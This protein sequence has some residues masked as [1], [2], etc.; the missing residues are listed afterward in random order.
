MTRSSFSFFGIL[1]LM[2]ALSGTARAEE[3]MVPMDAADLSTATGG[4]AT[5]NSTI[6]GNTMGAV[7]TTG[8][9][10]GINV[11]NNSGMTTLIEN[12]GNQVSIST[13]TVVNVTMH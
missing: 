6:T 7:G 5:V 1:A 2:L 12:S 8:S 3:A 13:A 11:G 10:S 9:I 4:S